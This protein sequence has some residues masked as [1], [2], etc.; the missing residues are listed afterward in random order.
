MKRIP[1][2]RRAV[3]PAI[4]TA[5]MRVLP[6]LRSTP[7]P[8]SAVLP[9]S[10]VFVSC[11]VPTAANDGPGPV[12]IPAPLSAVFSARRELSSAS[13]PVACQKIPPPGPVAA[14][15]WSVEYWITRV[16]APKRGSV[17][18]SIPPPAGGA[19]ATAVEAAVLPM[20][21][22]RVIC[23]MSV[24]CIQMPP[25]ST[26]ARLPATVV[27]SSLPPNVFIAIPPPAPFARLSVIDEFWIVSGLRL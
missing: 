4:V 23:E 24:F 20:I 19:P 21:S 2:P 22:D 27:L 12:E 6:V 26:P 7:P 14:F 17:S 16:V 18:T 15:P 5:R 1:L 8:R 9:A 11:T 3:L 10:V 25:P 13:V